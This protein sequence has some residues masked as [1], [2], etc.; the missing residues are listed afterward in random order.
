MGTFLKISKLTKSNTVLLK[1][2]GYKNCKIA[3]RFGLSKAS[4]SWILSRYK[5]KAHVFLPK[6]KNRYPGK[7]NNQD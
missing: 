7:N 5:E 1:E 6:Q 3:S 4:I 2:K